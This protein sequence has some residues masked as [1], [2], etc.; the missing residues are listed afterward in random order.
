MINKR[1]LRERDLHDRRWGVRGYLRVLVK[2]NGSTI[3]LEECR[4]GT[5]VLPEKGFITA[6]INQDCIYLT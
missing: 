2:F 3:D 1:K 4:L 6:Q 5:K